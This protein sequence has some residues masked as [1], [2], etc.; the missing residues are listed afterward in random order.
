MSGWTIEIERVSGDSVGLI[1]RLGRHESEASSFFPDLRAHRPEAWRFFRL[2]VIVGAAKMLASERGAEAPRRLEAALASLEDCKG[3]FTAVW[4]TKEGH[5]EFS[6]LI[7][8][9][10]ALEGENE[11]IHQV[12]AV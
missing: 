12:K 3:D 8:H 2:A 9:A 11:I 5:E 7:D 6:P 1:R 10:L 4:R